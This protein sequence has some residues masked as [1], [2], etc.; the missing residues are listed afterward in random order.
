VV[1]GRNRLRGLAPIESAGARILIL[2]S[3]PGAA[4]LQAQHYYAHPRNAFWPIMGALVGAGP[5]KSYDQRIAVLRAN[6]IA[7][8]DVIG[9]CQR[10][11]SLDSAISDETPNDFEGF[12]AAHR[13]ITLIGLNGGKAAAAFRKYAAEHTP[14]GATTVLLPSTS[15]AHARLSF[16]EKC[17]VWRQALKLGR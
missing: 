12:F 10:T 9:S 7:L 2:G 5:D 17:K 15:P 4:S 1:A 8:W 13:A 11:G 14:R 6:K 3:M 16:A